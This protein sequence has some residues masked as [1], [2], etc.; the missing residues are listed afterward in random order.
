M[1][2]RALQS[3]FSKALMTLERSIRPSKINK[4]DDSA[5]KTPTG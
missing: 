2:S 4:I 5:A 1:P 3:Y